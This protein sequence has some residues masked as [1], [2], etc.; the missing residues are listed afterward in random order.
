MAIRSAGFLA[1]A[2]EFFGKGVDSIVVLSVNDAF[3]MNA[4][5]K[6]L[7]AD[8]TKV[9]TRGHTHEHKDTPAR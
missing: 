4:W 1:S 8:T 5:A 2:E 9:S 3:V 6:S 7:N